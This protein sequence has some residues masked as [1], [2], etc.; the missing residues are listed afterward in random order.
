MTP[1]DPAPVDPEA[2]D[3]PLDEPPEAAPVVDALPDG[4]PDVEAVYDPLG[5][6]PPL[7]PPSPA[8]LPGEPH[9]EY[10]PASAAKAKSK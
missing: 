5:S 8:S 9:A 4:P 10:N 3:P 7:E 6:F 2:D 1:V